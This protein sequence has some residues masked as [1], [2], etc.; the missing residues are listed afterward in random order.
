ML[1]L[2]LTTIP[3]PDRYN[4]EMTMNDGTHQHKS[5]VTIKRQQWN[6]ITMGY[7]HSGFNV[8]VNGI[9]TSR[10]QSSGF[11]LKRG[12]RS[13]LMVGTLMALGSFH[14]PKVSFDEIAIWG[15]QLDAI[16]IKNI[17]LKNY[18]ASTFSL[19]FVYL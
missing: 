16:M 19:L 18:G 8:Y 15:G 10:S 14:G 2:F 11:R 9:E 17:V 3:I 5:T 4:F 12:K 6:H 1:V 13:T 7:H